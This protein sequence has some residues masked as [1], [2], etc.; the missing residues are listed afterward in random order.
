MAP[1]LLDADGGCE[2]VQPT[3]LAYMECP[4]V[5]LTFLPLCALLAASPVLAQDP[6][7]DE[8]WVQVVPDT[9][10]GVTHYIDMRSIRAG[11]GHRLAWVKDVPTVPRNGVREY[12][13]L[14]EANCQEPAM[15][16]L[17][18]VT[19]FQDGTTQTAVGQIGWLRLDSEFQDASDTIHR[20]V[21]RA[22]VR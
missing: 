12:R 22:S 10:L 15:R 13:S 3:Q 19:H 2:P 4:R 5:K 17:Q 1:T 14:F 16:M 11:S 20:A 21:C 6:S 18:T 7:S 9:G 8:Q